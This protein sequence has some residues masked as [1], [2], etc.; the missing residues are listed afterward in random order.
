MRRTKWWAAACLATVAACK[1]GGGTPPGDFTLS[2]S[3]VSFSALQGSALPVAQTVA[4]TVTGDGVAQV[5]VAYLNGQTK[6]SWLGIALSCAGKACQ[7]RLSILSTDLASGEHQST[8]AVGTAD[9]NGNVLQ[10]KEITVAYS[11]QLP[12]ADSPGA[13]TLDRTSADFAASVGGTPPPAIV[14]AVAVTGPGVASVTA[15]PRAGPLPAWLASSVACSGATCQVTLLASAGALPPGSYSAEIL[16]STRDAAGSVV[17]SKP[18]A[19]TF[20]LRPHVALS[21][22][23][24]PWSFT[25]GNGAQAQAASL[26]VSAVGRNW[27]AT[28]S[29]AWLKLAASSGQGSGTL[30]VTADATG[31]A[32]G[33][34]QAEVRLVNADDSLDAATLTVRADVALPALVV[35]PVS[36]ILGGAD[37]LDLSPQPIS[38]RL[39]R[40]A[41]HPFTVV[42]ATASGGDWLK[43]D[44]V[45]GSIGTNA[46]VVQASADRAGMAGGTYTGKLLVSATVVD[47]EVTAE[48][49]VTLQ[50]EASRL[51]V[52]AVGVSLLASPGR[53]VLSRDLT[54]RS[55]IGRTDIPWTATSS[56]AWLA[57]T[58]SGTTGGALTLTADPTDLAAGTHEATVTVSSSEAAVEN[59]QTVRVALHVLSAAPATL[60]LSYPARH[61]AASPVERLVFLNAGGADVVAYDVY[62]GALLRELKSVVAAAG[63]MAVSDDGR[64][65]FVH[66]TTN[67]RV[68]E[69][70]VVTGAFVKNYAASV[71]AGGTSG[72]AM[73]YFRPAGFPT[74]VTPSGRTYDLGTGTELRGMPTALDLAASP[75][76]ALVV[77]SYGSLYRVKRTAM[78]GGALER[79]YLFGAGAQGSEGQACIRSDGTTVYT[80]SGYPYNFPGTSIS[81]RQQVQT[82]PGAAYPDSIICLWNGLVVAGAD[83][84]YDAVD[85]WAYDGPSGVE[86]A[87]LSSASGTSYRSLLSRGLVAS[88]DA[89]RLVSLSS[90]SMGTLTGLQVR[91]Q[92]LPAA[93]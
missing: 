82:L 44:P 16:V 27:Q 83:A 21:G 72:W 38:V 61:A 71:A 56:A 26:A 6:P 86:L 78:S 85:V 24:G 4:L 7:L 64:R 18:V 68:T 53:S 11:V 14:L 5:G 40:G 31:L 32:P 80:A 60:S 55:T 2:S 77:T 91:L 9:G 79:T 17:L 22:T 67:L 59:E 48:V 73:L 45:A 33:A 66:D 89:T 57:A 37:G 50:L 10:A 1:S 3:R 42:A 35:S 69:V 36:L 76:Q 46:L 90:A 30:G 12:A 41:A 93:P 65:L 75:D 81:T 54:V 74:L 29:A 28:S 8:F 43:A 34:H 13:F 92:T 47:R 62:T 19:V 39:D 49:P 20:L 58:A 51:Q 84:Y 52:D 15:V 70:D 63:A 23:A 88:G 25:Y 87:K